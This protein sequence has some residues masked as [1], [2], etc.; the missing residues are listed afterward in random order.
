MRAGKRRSLSIVRRQ[1]TRAAND[2]AGG[3]RSTN[4]RGKRKLVASPAEGRAVLS[5]AEKAAATEAEEERENLRSAARQGDAWALGV[6]LCTL[7]IHQHR[8]RETREQ[9][10]S[11]LYLGEDDADTFE[12]KSR[13]SCEDKSTREK[14]TRATRTSVD[15]AVAA[16]ARA[17]AAAGTAAERRARVS[18]SAPGTMQAWT[19]SSQDC[20]SAESAGDGE[21]RAAK[22]ADEIAKQR[23]RQQ[24]VARLAKKGRGAQGMMSARA[25][26]PMMLKKAASWKQ[27]SVGKDLHKHVEEDEAAEA[28]SP[29]PSPPFHLGS[30][31]HS[32]Q[33]GGKDDHHNHN[34]LGFLS[35]RKRS[36]KHDG[37]GDGDVDAA[38]A[39]AAAPTA[40]PATTPAKPRKPRATQY[41]TL[42][43]LCQGKLSPLDGVSLANCPKPLLKL[44]TECCL[45]TPS[46]RPT[47]AQVASD[48]QGHVL[49]KLDPDTL[50][51]RR[52]D[53][54]LRGW[55][56]AIEANDPSLVADPAQLA[57]TVDA[58]AADAAAPA[59]AAAAPDDAADA[60]D[61]DADVDGD[62]LADG[63]VAADDDEQAAAKVVEEIDADGLRALCAEN[64]RP[65][66]EEEAREVMRL[67][68]ADGSGTLD[69]DELAPLLEMGFDM[70]E[71]REACAKLDSAAHRRS[72]RRMERA[73]LRER[74]GGRP[75][76]RKTTKRSEDD[77]YGFHDDTGHERE[78]PG[79][80][81]SKRRCKA[82]DARAV[83]G[84]RVTMAPQQPGPSMVHL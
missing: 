23:R 5:E 64:G 14:S 70:D 80:E 36:S 55:I 46:Q 51:A 67:L 71:L 63:L 18:F 4:A 83:D 17:A 28:P 53:T 74:S 78:G 21:S 75:A 79:R 60:A 7:A 68:D 8:Q 76:A 12:G 59:A 30:S 40:A 13:A 32:S 77:M 27:K 25:L 47:A 48:L 66:S 31:G 42:V 72:S 6:L 33:R 16:A 57:S 9:H 10:A 73:Q 50:E 45:V 44:A 15:R 35:S 37:D 24:Q 11:A 20:S 2:G 19:R 61:A 34:F 22:L 62:A 81:T 54:P 41:L 1:S 38:A 58:A 65:L 26:P 84:A 29:P 3:E 49:T 43:K 52:P 69:K 82:P 56:A 39:P